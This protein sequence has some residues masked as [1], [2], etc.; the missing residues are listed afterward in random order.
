MIRTEF[1]GAASPGDW[2]RRI[3]EQLLLEM[4]LHVLGVPA[5][6]LADDGVNHSVASLVQQG[7]PPSAVPP[8]APRPKGGDE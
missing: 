4:L 6:A 3:D 1:L 2:R 8:V 5:N 7:I